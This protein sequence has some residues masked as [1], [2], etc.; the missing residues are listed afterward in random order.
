M[1]R[2]VVMTATGVLLAVAAVGPSAGAESLSLA[3]ARQMVFERHPGLDALTEELRS[4]EE[5]VRQVSALE[6]PEIEIGTEQFG[7]NEVEVLITQP[8]PLGGARGAAIGKARQEIE[9]ARLN[10]ESERLAVEAELVR[11]FVA[12]LSAEGR[13]ALLDSLIEVSE[14]GIA[15]VSRLVDAGAAMRIDLVRT[16]LGRDE[17]LLDRLDFERALVQEKTSLAALW[18]ETEFRYDGLSG[19]IGGLLDVPSL[20]VLVEAIE[21]HPASMLLG[22]EKDMALAELD[23]AH[24][25]RWP[26][27]AL[28]AGYLQNNEADEGVPLVGVS[29]SLPIFDR[30]GASI[31][32]GRHNVAAAEHRRTLGRL[33][34]STTLSILYSELEGTHS[35]LEA[36]SGE[37][38]P[39]AARIHTDLQ[40]F[41]AGGRA[42]ILDVLEARGHL[43]EVRMRVV[44]LAEE[45]ALLRADLVELTGYEMEIIR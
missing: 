2:A 25:E 9:M 11:R 26:E 34:R 6:N 18:G 1:L 42:G 39:K 32:A 44:D 38:L 12:V 40:S 33:E 28:S 20:D 45:Q 4:A 27:L 16:E 19:S 14:K 29:I 22:V 7:R 24:A 8:I 15:A 17:L 3:E 36:V 21:V 31:A 35:R 13:V 10:L 5:T 43:L 41:Y 23:E 37:I 30:K